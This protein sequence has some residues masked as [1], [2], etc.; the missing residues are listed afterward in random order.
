MG[1]SDFQS[2]DLA[3]VLIS[4]FCGPL[5]SNNSSPTKVILFRE[6]T[7]LSL[8]LGGRVNLRLFPSV[9]LSLGQLDGLNVSFW[10]SLDPVLRFQYLFL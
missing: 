1:I 8:I 4:M 2:N 10:L 6:L 7:K 3:A 5:L 9:H